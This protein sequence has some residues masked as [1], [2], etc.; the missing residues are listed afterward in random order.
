[1]DVKLNWKTLC[2]SILT[3]GYLC[4]NSGRGNGITLELP[5]LFDKELNQ[6]KIRTAML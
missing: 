3:K 6:K 4:N 2:V 1:M 5:G